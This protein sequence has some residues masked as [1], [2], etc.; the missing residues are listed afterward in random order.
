MRE[1]FSA[2]AH[3]YTRG[4]LTSIP[5]LDTAEVSEERTRL[6]EIEGIVPS[7]A[8]L[9]PGCAFAP[10]CPYA[11]GECREARP[12]LEEKRSGHWIACWHADRLPGAAA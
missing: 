9:P 1:L 12:P 5:R 3:P 10:R 11:T 8:A 2:P 7:L 6:S 4:L